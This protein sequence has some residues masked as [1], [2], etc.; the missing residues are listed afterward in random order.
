MSTCYLPPVKVT[1]CIVLNDLDGFQTF[2]VFLKYRHTLLVYKIKS[3]GH[4]KLM[5]CSDT[6]I[7]Y[8]LANL[9]GILLHYQN[10]RQ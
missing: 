8:V 9:R 7:V 10:R 2:L 4:N 5:L 3:N 1:E 6:R